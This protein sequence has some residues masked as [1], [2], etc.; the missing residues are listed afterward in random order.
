M[1]FV[2]EYD[3]GLSV[4]CGLMDVN[5]LVGGVALPHRHPLNLG[6][7][8]AN[9]CSGLSSLGSVFGGFVFV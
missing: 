5:V 2:I 4:F 7:T 1:C 9:S 3:D 6:S 8:Y